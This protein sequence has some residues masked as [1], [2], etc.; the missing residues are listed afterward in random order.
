MSIIKWSTAGATSTLIDATTGTSG[1]SAFNLGATAA[2]YGAD[3]DNTSTGAG[4]Q[5]ANFVCRVNMSQASSAA[6][7]MRAWLLLSLDGTTSLYESG[8]TTVTPSRPADLIF[9]CALTSGAQVVALRTM[10]LPRAR[11]KPLFKNE[12]GYALSSAD[13]TSIG[14]HMTPFNEEIV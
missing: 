5:Y 9:P 12:T 13:S 2:C 8:S 1:P 4:W 3:Y 14:L 10:P 11:F 7:Y 6:P